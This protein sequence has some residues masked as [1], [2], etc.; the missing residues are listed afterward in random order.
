MAS[1]CWYVVGVT[2]GCGKLHAPRPS[3]PVLF[4][5]LYNHSQLC[6]VYSFTHTHTTHTQSEAL[7]LYG[8]MLLVVDMKME[9]P[10]RERMLVAFHRYSTQQT[11]VDSNIDDVC[12][13]LR[14]TGYLRTPVIKRP[15]KYP[16]DFFR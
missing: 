12:K 15:P 2:I 4:I 5:K 11:N 16:E 14:S 13:L 3:D 6:R 8:V 1:S 10:V 9:G 7:F